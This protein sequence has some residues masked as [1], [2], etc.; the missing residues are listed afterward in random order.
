M[1]VAP[2]IVRIAVVAS[3]EIFPRI[4]E[5]RTARAMPPH[6]LP[7][8]AAHRDQ[9]GETFKEVSGSVHA[10]SLDKSECCAE[11]GR[12]PSGG[13]PAFPKKKKKKGAKKK[14]KKKKK[15]QAIV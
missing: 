13:E 10:Q 9:L 7:M 5:R 12:R 14:K 8:R 2:L 15:K 4:A 1:V 3:P 11:L 6:A